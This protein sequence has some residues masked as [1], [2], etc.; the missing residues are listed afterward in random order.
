MTVVQE[1]TLQLQT[2]VAAVRCMTTR[3]V[4]KACQLEYG[5]RIAHEALLHGVHGVLE[6]EGPLKLSHLDS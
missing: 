3:T 1:I 6:A 4:V 5:L 2:D